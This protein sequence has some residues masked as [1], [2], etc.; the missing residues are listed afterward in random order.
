VQF[1]IQHGLA[2]LL[3]LWETVGM[4][5]KRTKADKAQRQANQLEKRA[6]ARPEQT[7][8]KRRLPREDFSPAAARIVREATEQE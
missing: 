7:P 4:A 6:D 5:T 8:K 1:E 3:G 2:R